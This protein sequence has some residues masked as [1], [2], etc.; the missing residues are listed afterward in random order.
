MSFEK[1]FV[2]ENKTKQGVVEDIHKEQYRVPFAV[3]RLLCPMK[4]SRRRPCVGR[5]K[6]L[7]VSI[8]SCFKNWRP[9][10]SLCSSWMERIKRRLCSVASFA[11]L[12]IDCLTPFTSSRKSVL[13]GLISRT[14]TDK[15][16]WCS[17]TVNGF[18]PLSVAFLLIKTI[19]SKRTR[20]TRIIYWKMFRWW[21]R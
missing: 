13:R 12:A 3:T 11:F 9:F 16:A 18:C 21:Y 1:E 20:G 4:E 5:A 17:F 8:K 10:E 6:R 19:H 2:V 15:W 7:H 14:L